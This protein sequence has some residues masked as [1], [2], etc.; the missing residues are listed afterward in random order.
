MYK[1][2]EI[3]VPIDFSDRS[4]SALEEAGFLAQ[5]TGSKLFAFHAIRRPNAGP[6]STAFH[7]KGLLDHKLSELNKKYQNITQ[8]IK[9]FK[10]L[11][12]SIQIQPGISKDNITR[13]I[14]D[15][16]IDL[17]VSAT[18]GAEGI[19]MVLGS[20]TQKLIHELKGPI[21][22]IP[23]GSKIRTVKKIALAID[24]GSKFK[25]AAVEP[26]LEMAR[27]LGAKLY[28]FEVQEYNHPRQKEQAK[29]KDKLS[30]LGC[31]D[32]QVVFDTQVDS[33][34]EDGIRKFIKTF[35]IDML[36][37]IPLHRNPLVDIFHDSLSEKM[38]GTAKIPILTL[39]ENYENRKL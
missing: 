4:I 23:D 14:H 1:L 17:I 8:R 31:D 19:E 12:H 5:Q 7:N 28:V 18:H 26:I 27:I 35:D 9:E 25:M 30:E 16:K 22:V 33:H 24:F 11:D 15:E 6:G 13:V 29:F 2:E 20:R 21:L 32:I 10:N 37:L 36:G 34:V 38:A 39:A 3:L